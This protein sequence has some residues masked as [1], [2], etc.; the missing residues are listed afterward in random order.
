M[1]S[2]TVVLDISMSLDGFVAAANVRPEAP[3]GDGGERLHEWA[4]GGDE[5]DRQ[6]LV[7]GGS[8]TGAVICGRRT[9]DLSRPWWGADG[10]TGPARLPVIVLT[11]DP[12]ADPPES[13]V[14]R[15][16]SGVEQAL[17]QARAAAGDKS[18]CV[19]GGADAAQQYLAAGLVD[20]LSIHLVPVLFGDG[21]RLFDRAHPLTKLEAIDTAAAT[22]LRFSTAVNA[23]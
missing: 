11:H 21:I 1:Q 18:V 15:F 2:N 22:H 13:G 12:P 4:F 14:Y 20:E 10:P 19:M 8:A 7:E 5:R 23:G 6:V 17:E 9:Y 3:I 16:V